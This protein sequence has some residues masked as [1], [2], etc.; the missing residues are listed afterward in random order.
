MVNRV[1]KK[2]HGRMRNKEREDGSRA[3]KQQKKESFFLGDAGC[4]CV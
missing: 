4:V 3:R 2:E 1:S